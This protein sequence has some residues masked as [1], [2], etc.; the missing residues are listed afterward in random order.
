MR[1]FPSPAAVRVRACHVVLRNLERM[2]ISKCHP[3]YQYLL[4][5]LLHP[6]KFTHMPLCTQPREL[7]NKMGCLMPPQPPPPP[8]RSLGFQLI[9]VGMASSVHLG[10][11]QARSR[12]RRKTGEREP[13][14]ILLL[15]PPPRD[16]RLK[17]RERLERMVP[18]KRRLRLQAFHDGLCALPC[19]RTWGLTT[20]MPLGGKRRV[21]TRECRSS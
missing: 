8:T 18:W 14:V 11:P 16:L 1:K 17:I 21:E 4:P 15:P 3:P 13:R 9:L 20:A 7:V 5:L 6:R 2:A 19:A 10:N 12:R